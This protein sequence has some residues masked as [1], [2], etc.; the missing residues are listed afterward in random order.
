MRFKF[1]NFINQNGLEE[2]VEH[3]VF[4]YKVNNDHFIR[5]GHRRYNNG[6]TEALLPKDTVTESPPRMKSIARFRE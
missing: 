3:S 5:L 6:T 1:T 2:L 4:K